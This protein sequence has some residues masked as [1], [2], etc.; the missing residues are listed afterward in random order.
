VST[1]LGRVLVVGGTGMLAGATRRLAAQAS[2][3]TLVARNP[4][5]L[6]ADLGARSVAL[7]WAAPDAPSRV[8]AIWDGFDLAVIWLHDDAAHLARPFE[9]L[10]RPGGRVIRVH[11]SRSVDP[12][13]RAARDPDP[14]PGLHRQVVILGWHPDPLAAGGRRWLADDEI[15]AGVLAALD[16]P[17]LGALI[18]GGAGG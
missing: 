9:D 10:L 11:G 3:L 18:V 12:V 1:P 5:P 13:V 17:A 4:G 7:D 14:R 15:C 2:A 6:A 16:H 8:A